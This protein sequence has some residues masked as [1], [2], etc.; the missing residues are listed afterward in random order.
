MPFDGASLG[1][2]EELRKIDSVIDLIGTPDKWCKGSIRTGDG[3]FCLR[4]AM[5]EVDGADAMSPAILAAVYDVTGRHYRRIESFNDHPQ[6]EHD[7]VIAVLMRAREH[8]AAGRV[9]V[10]ETRTATTTWRTSIRSW[11]DIFAKA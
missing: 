8:V 5:R 2:A 9:I 4:G 3:R 6:T 7:Q 10:P 1:A 11:F